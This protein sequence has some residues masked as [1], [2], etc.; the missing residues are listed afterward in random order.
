MRK[1]KHRGPFQA[2]CPLV[3]A[4]GSPRRRE[5]LH[6]IGLEFRVVS[7]DIPEPP[8]EKEDPLAYALAM[9]EK[10]G[11][12]VSGMYPESWIISADTIVVTGKQVL[13]KP[14]TAEEA[15]AML[16]ALSGRWHQ[17][18]SA[19]CI[20]NQSRSQALKNSVQSRVKFKKLTAPEI[21]SYVATGEC[22]DKAGAYAVQGV[23]AFMIEKIEGSYTNVVGLPL[24]ELVDGLLSLGII[25]PVISG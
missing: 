6:N 7:S 23:G 3:L 10:K 20:M 1:R 2:S 19:F 18:I 22:M 24:C 15:A 5:F 21:K 4:S 17:V 12:M 8:F 11:I 9:A 16:R 14:K 13:G 25:K